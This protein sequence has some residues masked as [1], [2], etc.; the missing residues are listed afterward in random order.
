MNARLQSALEFLNDVQN[1]TRR[2]RRAERLAWLA[3][4][5]LAFPLALFALDMLIPLSRTGRILALVLGIVGTAWIWKRNGTTGKSE[6]PREALART[7]EQQF[8][9]TDNALIHAVQFA[10]EAGMLSTVDAGF[11]AR[12]RTRADQTASQIAPASC[13]N[14][15]GLRRL[16]VLL[17]CLLLVWVVLCFWGWRVVRFEVPRFAALNNDVPPFTL[18]D[19][20]LTPIQA[21]VP[22]GGS[23]KITVRVAGRL[24]SRLNLVTETEG[25]TPQSVPMTSTDGTTYTLTLENLTAETRFYAEGDT[26]RST[27]GR[28]AILPPKSQSA[29][30]KNAKNAK[31]APKSSQSMQERR[32]Q[33]EVREARSSGETGTGRGDPKSSRPIRKPTLSRETAEKLRNGGQ[34]PFDA[35]DT[36]GDSRYPVAYR[37]LLREYFQSR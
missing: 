21:Q 5:C 15:A 12:E 22:S 31:S 8:P 17:I 3:A 1:L 6:L 13:V 30:S 9:Q 24:P 29:A 14:G 11:L 35:N 25:N 23:V 10:N 34:K 27:S 7:V 37:R 4:F 28:I 19:F 2:V 16:R 18:T 32:G 26:G 33:K 20:R 36:N